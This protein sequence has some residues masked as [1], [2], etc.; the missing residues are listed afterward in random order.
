[1]LALS[2]RTIY[3]LPERYAPFEPGKQS[4]GI[5]FTDRDNSHYNRQPV[6]LI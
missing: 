3:F 6:M 1:M 2:W 4:I 5:Q